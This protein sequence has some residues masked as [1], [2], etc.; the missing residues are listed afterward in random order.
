M[1]T[2][3][4]NFAGADHKVG[5]TMLVQSIADSLMKHHPDRKVLV[6]HL[7]GR[8]GG[9]FISKPQTAP[10]IDTLF[11]PLMQHVAKYSE[12]S[13]LFI[14]E[15]SVSTL[16]GCS[17][18]DNCVRYTPKVTQDII[19]L[20]KDYFDIVLIDSGATTHWNGLAVGA[21]EYDC[22]NVLVTTQQESAYTNFFNQSHD[23]YM[24]FTTS[25]DAVIVNRFVFATGNFLK[26][27]KETYERYGFTQGGYCVINADSALQAE[28]DHKSLYI[29][30]KRFVKDIDLITENLIL[31]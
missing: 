27:E 13:E 23:V 20:C 4:F 30:D 26:G 11:Q 14:T 31:G 10:N 29:Y 6:L 9:D 25:W 28:S 24:R 3:I 1:A 12:L 8:E 21:F 18:N 5:T 19:N 17:S 22:P 2:K 16:L 15:S 7:D